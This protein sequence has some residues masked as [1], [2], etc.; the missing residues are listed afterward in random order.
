MI[1]IISDT[2]QD[3]DNLAATFKDSTWSHDN[4]QNYFKR[5]EHNLYLPQ[6][7]ASSDHGFNGWL[8]T[9]LNPVQVLLNPMFL[10]WSA[11]IIPRLTVL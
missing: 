3:F 9:S 4:M 7:L 6:L 1:N 8:K 5:L 11:Q 2:R 10:G